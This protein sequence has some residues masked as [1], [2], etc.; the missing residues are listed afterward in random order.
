MLVYF[1]IQTE[2]N[3]KMSVWANNSSN[4]YT[5]TSKRQ[6]DGGNGTIQAT[7][8]ALV[9]CFIFAI[10]PTYQRYW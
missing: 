8:N 4:N 5:Q 3:I 1:T 10:D 7:A 9:Y 6:L 2:L